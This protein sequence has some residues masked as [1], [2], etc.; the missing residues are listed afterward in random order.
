MIFSI[1]FSR[2]YQNVF[3]LAGHLIFFQ[4]T[5]TAGRD[6]QRETKYHRQT[7]LQN[8]GA[9]EVKVS[10]SDHASVGNERM[11]GGGVTE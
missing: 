4:P 10:T 5:P 7:K 6:G 11:G 8:N 3:V 2:C 1:M 9:R